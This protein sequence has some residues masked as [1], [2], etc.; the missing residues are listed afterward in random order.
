[1]NTKTKL[2]RLSRLLIGKKEE[3]KIPKLSRDCRTPKGPV[4]LQ[5][6]T[7]LSH[8]SLCERRKSRADVIETSKGKATDFKVQSPIM[9]ITGQS[10]QRMIHPSLYSSGDL[11][12]CLCHSP[13]F[14]SRTFFFF[15][16]N[17]FECV[18]SPSLPYSIRVSFLSPKWFLSQWS[19]FCSFL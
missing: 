18:C 3:N 19:Y 4:L 12:H 17:I 10:T 13:L 9:E 16:A 15:F 7:S 5:R 8:I 14:S 2:T 11:G 1:M 6:S